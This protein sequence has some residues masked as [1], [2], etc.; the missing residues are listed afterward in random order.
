MTPRE[1]VL[2]FWEAMRSNDFKAASLW[3]TKDFRQD[4]PQS[5][6]I[7]R[8]RDDFA[9]INTAY[10]ASGLWQFDLRWIV[11]EGASVVTEVGVMDGTLQATVL[12][13]HTVDGDLISRQ[14]EFWP[15][16]YDPPAWRSQWVSLDQ[17]RPT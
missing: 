8:G 13:H 15:D 3:L 6:E 2:G 14:R 7:I 11:A 17:P 12:T 10:P 1:V 9:A 4:W 5:G 16:P